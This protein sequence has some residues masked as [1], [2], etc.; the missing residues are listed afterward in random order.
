MP[1]FISEAKIGRLLG[2]LE[3]IPVENFIEVKFVMKSDLEPEDLTYYLTLDD[4][5]DK[6]VKVKVNF[7]E[8]LLVSKGNNK[9]QVIVNIKEASIFIGLI[10]GMTLENNPTMVSEFPSQVPK[11]VD[12]D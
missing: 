10:G 4:W 6:E 5:Q 1:G 8:P 12:A 2:S 11:D 7:V 3:S 9:D